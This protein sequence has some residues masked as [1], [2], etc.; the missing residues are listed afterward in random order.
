[1]LFFFDLF[2]SDVYADQ[3][4]DAKRG[5]FSRVSPSWGKTGFGFLLLPDFL[6]KCRRVSLFIIVALHYL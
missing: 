5:D 3:D 6:R 2:M 4:D 1:L